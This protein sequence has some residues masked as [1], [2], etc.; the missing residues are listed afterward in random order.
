VG[1]AAYSST[2]WGTIATRF[3]SWEAS[4]TLLR[5]CR[6]QGWHVICDLKTNRTLDGRPL[7]TYAQLVRHQRYDRTTI[8]ATDG[9]KTRQSPGCNQ[10]LSALPVENLQLREARAFPFSPH[11]RDTNKSA[12][13]QVGPQSLV[14]RPKHIPCLVWQPHTAESGLPR[15]ASRSRVFP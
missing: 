12:R 6:R 1:D 5:F 7:R 13:S 4:T 10:A 9:M 15:A 14:P 11:P 8:R 3:D 2:R